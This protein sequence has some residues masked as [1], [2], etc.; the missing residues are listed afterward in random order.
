[1]SLNLGAPAF[2]A[3]QNLKN[4]R[5]W[6]VFKSALHAQMNTSI[7]AALEANTDRDM[8][9]GYARAIRDVV[10]Q[11]ETYE[12]GPQKNGRMQRPVI[13]SGAGNV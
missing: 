12:Q 4:G 7:H 10:A 9:V 1:M 5:D 8:A 3:V 11:I 2:D 6:Q 13:G